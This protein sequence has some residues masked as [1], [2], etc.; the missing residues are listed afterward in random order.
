M[1]EEKLERSIEQ[2]AAA[3]T[4]MA[5]DFFDHPEVGLQEFHAFE[6]LTGWLEK[7][8][9]TVERGIAGMKT[10]FRAVWKHGEG[11]PNIGLLCEYD[12]LAGLG[13]A[14]GH[15]MQG[16]AILGA[17]K[18]LKDAAIDAPYTITVYGTPAEETISG[19]VVML[20]NGCTFEELDVA[21][22]M[23]GGPALSLIHI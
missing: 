9:F 7:E 21:L 11:G 16:P 8:G 4:A 22:M 5:D 2:S 1:L 10:A 3:L 15:H 13:H 20:E 12:A 19:K 23:H 17:A 18:A 14:C 6:T